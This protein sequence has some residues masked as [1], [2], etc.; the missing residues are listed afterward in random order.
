MLK[1]SKSQLV[2]LGKDAE[3]RFKMLLAAANH[4]FEGMK[5]QVQN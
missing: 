4:Y 5:Q 2:A 1:D 3:D